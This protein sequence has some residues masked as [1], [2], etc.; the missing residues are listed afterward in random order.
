MATTFNLRKLLHRKAWERCTPAPVNTAAGSFIVSDKFN[1]IPN[2]LAYL[3]AG[4]SAIYRYDGDEDSWVQLPNSGLAGVFG[5]GACGEFRALGAMGGAFTQTATAGGANSI[6][7][8]DTIVRNLAGRRI[9]VVAGTGV[10]FDGTIVSN[11]IGANAVLTTSG[12]TFDATTQYQIFSGSLWFQNAG[13]SAGF[14][15]YDLATNAWTA[16]AATGVTFG[17]DG[18]LISTLSSAGSFFTGTAS[19]GGSTTLTGQAGVAWSSNQWANAYQ[20][21][22]TSGTGAGQIRPIA[23]NTGTVLTVASAWTVNPDATS[24]YVIEGD[25]DKFY[26][27]GNNAVTLY[28]YS[29]SANTWTTITPGSARAGAAGAGATLNW[30]DS[31]AG[32]DL[33]ANGSPSPLTQGGTVVFKQKGRYLFSFRGGGTSTLDIYDI[34]ANTW[35][36]GVGYGNQLETFTTGSASVDFGGNIYIQKEPTG[37]PLVGRIFR[38]NVEAFSMQSFSVNIDLQ[39]ATLVGQKMFMLPYI[40]GGTEIEFLYTMSHTQPTLSRMIVI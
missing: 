36:S 32:W 33:L 15:V 18:Q 6:T 28:R 34:A 16:R 7:T 31:V 10:G 40:D 22:I 38:F 24:V 12:G 39:G 5:P 30:I 9:R 25:D 19:A 14:G 35:I 23:S 8:N 1:I 27:I 29:V 26:L 21:R 11:T 17:T 13:A 4:A 20:V 3:V 37:T 2:S